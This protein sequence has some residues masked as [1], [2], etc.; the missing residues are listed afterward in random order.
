[1]TK[2]DAFRD[3][4]IG[5]TPKTRRTKGKN[6]IILTVKKWRLTDSANTLARYSQQSRNG[7]SPL[8]L[9]KTV[10]ENPQKWSEAEYSPPRN[11]NK[12]RM[13]TL[14]TPL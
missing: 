8:S 4:K 11:M 9:I 6:R 3:C 12:T 7:E 2:E 14:T 5:L 10:Y 1:M 13:P